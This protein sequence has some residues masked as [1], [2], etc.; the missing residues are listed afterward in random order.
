MLTSIDDLSRKV[1]VHFLVEKSETFD[2]VFLFKSYALIE[3]ESISP[4][5][6]LNFVMNK[7]KRVSRSFWTG[8]INWV[9]HVLNRSSILTVKNITL[10]EAWSGI[11]PSISYFRIFGCIGYVHVL[12]KK[13][14]NLMTKVSNAYKLYAPVKKK[15]LVNSSALEALAT[16]TKGRSKKPLAWMRDYVTGEDLTKEDVMNFAMFA[17]TYPVAFKQ[18]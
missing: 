10:E 4:M 12:D 17:S 6:L 16:P 1:R 13:G 2:L 11:K 3:R 15:L 14:E 5:S 8:V 7:E 9:V 18:A